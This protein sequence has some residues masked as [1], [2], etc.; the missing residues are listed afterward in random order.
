[1][2]A[3]PTRG[4]SEGFI[5]ISGRRLHYRWLSPHLDDTPVVFLHEGLGSVERWKGFPSEIVRRTGHPGLLYS[6]YG[7]GWS[8]PLHEPR[9]WDYM[10]Q[11][12]LRSLPE[13]VDSLV[14]RAPILVGHSDGASI[15][16]IYAGSGGPVEGLVLLAPHVFV[17]QETVDQIASSLAGFHGSEML[18]KM[19]KYHAEPEMTFRGW[20]DIWLSPTFRA[21]NIEEYLAGVVCPCLLIQGD[22]DEYGTTRQLDVIE[23]TVPAPVRRLVVGDA[24]HSPHLSHPDLVADAVHAFVGGLP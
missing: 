15:A 21:W 8:E 7:N 24:G 18:E 16:L 11:E 20:A 10:H 14:K 6:R 17:E 9:P 2:S 5:D 19:T 13:I 22:G 12:A 1:V 3:V 23:K 4:E